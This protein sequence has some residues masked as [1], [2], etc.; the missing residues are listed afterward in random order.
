MRGVLIRRGRVI[1]PSRKL[2][3]VTDVLIEGDVIRAV[4]DGVGAL[5][6]GPDFETIDVP[7]MIV[8]PGFV[9]L[10]AH[11]R[12]PGTE[13]ETI[14]SGGLAAVAGGFTTICVM[15][16]TA[17]AIDSGERVAW[18]HERSRD[19]MKD[20]RG[21]APRLK[22]VGALTAERKGERPSDMLAM[23]RAG[24]VAFSD[25]GSGVQNAGVMRNAMLR[26]A[27][28]GLAVSDHA[29]DACLA[30]IGVINEGEISRKW[31]IPGKSAVAEEAMIARDIE[32]ARATGAHLHVAHLSTARGVELVRRAKNDGV[33]VTAEVTPHHLAL[34]EY[35]LVKREPL[36]DSKELKRRSSDLDANK[37]MNPPLRTR[38]DQEALVEGLRDGTIDAIATD[39]AP[40][41]SA[42]KAA[43]IMDAPNGVIGL[44][45]AFAVCYA[46]LSSRVGSADKPLP[47]SRVIEL[48][49]SGPAS[50]FGL[51]AGTLAPGSKADLVILSPTELWKF[52]HERVASASWN[53]P[54]LDKDLFG[55]VLR[56]YVDGRVAFQADEARK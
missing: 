3:R 32:I 1:D 31:G 6:T 23:A 11:F 14:E 50:I 44:Q 33:R 46:T 49:T 52:T 8:A 12:E 56:T 36:Y 7:D 37:K 15:P 55:R 25:D 26:A 30:G 17:P 28:L 4:G 45:T 29:E 34:D 5:V 42:K 54:W 9:D 27:E 13:G 24:A 43:G 48:L 39:H 47:I 38:A 41:P 53:S 35:A 10:H 18:Q 40:H 21:R 22:V 51:N 16:N 2:D 19:A 20:T